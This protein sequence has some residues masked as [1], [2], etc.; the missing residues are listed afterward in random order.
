VQLKLKILLTAILF[1]T[2]PLI[3]SAAEP[4]AFGNNARGGKLPF[5]FNFSKEDCQRVFT[6][7][8][9]TL[10]LSVQYP[11]MRLVK[12]RVLDGELISLRMSHIDLERYDQDRVIEGRKPD[13]HI[14]DIDVYVIGSSDVYRFRGKDGVIVFVSDW[15][16]TY[17]A[18]RLF[19]H[20]ISISYQYSSSHKNV[21]DMDAAVLSFLDE[22]LIR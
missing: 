21:K 14:G 5:K 3:G 2:I 6:R 7:D 9:S 1:I 12:E 11:E 19:A 10:T 4:C 20:D 8:G 17:V 15:G 13:R 16:N 18:T 22:H